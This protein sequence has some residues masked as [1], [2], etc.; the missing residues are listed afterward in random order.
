MIFSTC[1]WTFHS[2]SF[3]QPT[4]Q[5]SLNH[6]LQPFFSPL[7][8]LQIGGYPMDCSNQQHMCV[9]V[10]LC[11][12]FKSFETILISQIASMFL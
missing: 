2:L 10:R 5:H 11:C 7:S 4:S 3:L 8:I 9:S 1:W 6:T 12:C